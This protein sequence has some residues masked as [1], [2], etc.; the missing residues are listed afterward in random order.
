MKPCGGFRNNVG[1]NLEKVQREDLE[2]I[3]ETQ[4]SQQWREL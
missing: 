1:M 2:G 3:F 4:F